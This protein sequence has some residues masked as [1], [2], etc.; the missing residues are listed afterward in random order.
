MLRLRADVNLL[1]PSR[2]THGLRKA[3]AYLNHGLG[4]G[5]PTV[6]DGAGPLREN[7]LNAPGMLSIRGR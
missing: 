3:W 4:L 5:P 6:V 7:Q 2:Q 1:F